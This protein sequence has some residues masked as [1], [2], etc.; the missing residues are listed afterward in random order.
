MTWI[1]RK[2]AGVLPGEHIIEGEV[3]L[4]LAL[5]VDQLHNRNLGNGKHFEGGNE[6]LNLQNI[7]S[8]GWKRPWQ[9][10]WR[11]HCASR[12][13]VSPS[14]TAPLWSW[15]S[16][17]PRYEDRKKFSVGLDDQKCPWLECP[18]K[19]KDRAQWSKLHLVGMS[20][21]V[22]LMS[23]SEWRNANPLLKCWHASK[24]IDHQ[25]YV[26]Y[27]FNCQKTIDVQDGNT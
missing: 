3:G 2:Q 21:K 4:N 27:L 17:V 9:R 25:F 10:W 26:V 5:L 6:S 23:R 18:K 19:D 8:R 22:R 11:R 1:K 12:P 15:C 14:Q 7:Q 13:S 16:Q 20:L 24:L